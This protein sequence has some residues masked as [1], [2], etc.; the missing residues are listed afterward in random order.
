MAAI[1]KKRM[2]GGSTNSL[3][4]LK[5]GEYVRFNMGSNQ[6]IID[7]VIPELRNRLKHSQEQRFFHGAEPRVE[8]EQSCS[9]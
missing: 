8:M 1:P 2:I 6:N 7:E 3:S 4:T 5:E 9:E